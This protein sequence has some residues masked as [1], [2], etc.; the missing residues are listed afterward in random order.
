MTILIAILS[1]SG[2]SIGCELRLIKRRSHVRIL[3]PPTL[4]WT[5]QKKKKLFYLNVIII[6][7][8]HLKPITKKS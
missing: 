8:I 5:C 4:A 2:N 6:T 7:P 1:S 3:P